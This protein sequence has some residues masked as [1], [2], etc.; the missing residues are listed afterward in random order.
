MFPGV[1]RVMEDA[2]GHDEVERGLRKRELPDVRLG[3]DDVGSSREVPVGSLDGI[4][5]VDAD[6]VR[7]PSCEHVREA[8]GT[9]AGVQDE[10]SVHLFTIEPGLTFENLLGVALPG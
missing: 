8:S 5:Q 1:R 2:D 3:N 6:D 10:L 9:D 4:A 7:S